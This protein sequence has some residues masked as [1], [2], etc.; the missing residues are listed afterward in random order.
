MARKLLQCLIDILFNIVQKLGIV[1]E[2]SNI[3]LTE[4]HLDEINMA[5]IRYKKHTSI[6][7][8]KNRMAE[9]NNPTLSF[10]F[11]CREEIFKEIDK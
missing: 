6:K 2:K 11:I 1:I 7:A 8:I 10:D 3:K 4:L 5:I 9:P